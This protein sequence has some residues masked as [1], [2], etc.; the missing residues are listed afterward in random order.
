MISKDNPYVY[1]GNEDFLL[2]H[3]R[4]YTAT[5]F[6]DGA[7][8][9]APRCCFFNAIVVAATYGLAYVEGYAINEYGVPVHHAWNAD[10]DRQVLDSTWLQ[11]P[12]YAF[13]GV[14]FSVERADDATWNGDASIL[15]DWK[16]GWPLFKSAT[17]NGE[18]YSLQWPPSERLDSLRKLAESLKKASPL[19]SCYR[20]VPR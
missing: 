19:P 2:K 3:G 12:G 4:E 14:E 5:P 20:V 15:D 1:L 8:R 7:W 11:Y 13:F 9:G 17:W 10:A 18:D 6:P 16:R